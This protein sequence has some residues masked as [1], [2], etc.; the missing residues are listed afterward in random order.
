MDA[1]LVNPF[2]DGY[3]NWDDLRQTLQFISRD[4]AM[5][6]TSA[7]KQKSFNFAPKSSAPGSGAGVYEIKFRDVTDKLDKLIFRRYF[8]RRVKPLE[9]DVVTVQDLRDIALYLANPKDLSIEFINYFHI[10]PVDR[11]LRALIIYFQ[12]YLDVWEVIESKREEKARKIRQPIAL[13]LEDVVRDN[14]EDL[15]ALVAREYLVIIGGVGEAKKFHHMAGRMTS[16][17]GKDRRLFEMLIQMAVRVV[18]IALQ[19]KHLLL[20]ELEMNRMFRGDSFNLVTHRK[21]VNAS[22]RNPEEDRVLIGAANLFERKLLQRSPVIKELIFAE[23]DHR[24]LGAGVRLFQPRDDRI[25]FIE[26]CYSVPEEQINKMGIALGLLG[27][28]REEF[29]P[30]LL[31]RERTSKTYTKKITEIPEFKLP[32]KTDHSYL[33]LPNIFPKERGRFEETAQSI[34]AREAQCRMWVRHVRCALLGFPDTTSDRGRHDSLSRI[35]VTSGK[36]EDETL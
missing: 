6:T 34:N 18:W 10:Q 33:E 35:S 15:R 27:I 9:P 22:K 26:A 23:H 30:V 2:S 14:L 31:S 7:I 19:R 5:R 25:D 21:N 3:W 29:D 11:F 4:P 12:Y 36:G 16:L 32:P 8:Q 20:I 13:E 17:S 28:P 24:L 1:Q